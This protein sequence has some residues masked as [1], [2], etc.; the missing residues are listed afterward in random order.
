MS[1]L[2]KIWKQ[3]KYGC[4]KSK[5]SNG[6]MNVSVGGKKKDSAPFSWFYKIEEWNSLYYCDMCS[7]F[8]IQVIRQ[9]FDCGFDISL[10][11]EQVGSINL[12]DMVV[13]ND[14]GDF[15]VYQFWDHG[16]GHHLEVCTYDND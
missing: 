13:D 15:L 10:E 7:Q 16:E 1:E 12:R 9:G 14:K 3:F 2:R 5:L 11:D 8:P 4:L 6:F